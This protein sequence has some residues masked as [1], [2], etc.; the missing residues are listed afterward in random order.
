MNEEIDLK[1]IE[2]KTYHE[3]M[4]DGITETL[5]GIILIFT[6]LFILNPIFVVFVPFF[7]LF[8]R[9]IIETIRERTTYPRIGRVE[10]ILEEDK[11]DF[12]VKRTFLEFSLFILV[13][14]LVTFTMMFIFEGEILDASLWYKWVPLLFGL[15]MF[16]PSLF[17][18]EK[19]GQRRYY[20]F[21]LCSTIF[22]LL[23]SVLTFPDVKD[24]MFLY[25]FVLG[26]II[27]FLGISRY[28]WFIRNY[29]VVHIE[30]E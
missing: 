7:I 17:L 2:Q 22:G 1:E 26:I 12:S 19:T 15:I 23:F 10:F 27:M 13:T 8:N 16:G 5:A 24:G 9:H 18:V 21:G 4:I 20:L 30:E 29:P 3:F 14:V 28:I 25:F 11:G 6:P